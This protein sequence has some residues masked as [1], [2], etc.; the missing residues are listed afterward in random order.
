[1]SNSPVKETPEATQDPKGKGKAKLT[2]QE[3][4]KDYSRPGTLHHALLHSHLPED[5][6]DDEFAL[7]E[8]SFSSSDD[9]EEYD[10]DDEFDQAESLEG[11]QEDDSSKNVQETMDSE[12]ADLLDE[13]QEFGDGGNLVLGLRSGRLKVEAP[14]DFWKPVQAEQQGSSSAA[15]SSSSKRPAMDS[16][17]SPS[18]KKPRH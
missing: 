5:D 14:A 12:I 11:P 8:E 7:E 1:M 13:A 2:V 10:S 6:E 17:S 18:D 4:P 15:A 3:L 16:E 9:S